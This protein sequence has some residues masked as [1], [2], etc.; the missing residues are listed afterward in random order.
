MVALYSLFIVEMAVI[1]MNLMIGIAISN[2][3]VNRG[4]GGS[5]VGRTVN[6]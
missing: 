6:K 4:S 3:Q 2:I 1:L 5:V